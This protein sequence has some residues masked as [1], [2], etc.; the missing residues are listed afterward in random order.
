MK[1]LLILPFILLTF[2][3]F[4]QTN[5]NIPNVVAGSTQFIPK[6]H[7]LDT[8]F[9]KQ[10]FRTIETGTSWQNSFFWEIGLIHASDFNGD[11]E[12]TDFTMYC[13]KVAYTFTPF[14]KT[15]IEGP[16]VSAELNLFFLTMR[17]NMM[18]YT[19][20]YD[21]DTHHDLRF[22]PEIG[23]TVFGIT[24]VCYGWNIPLLKDRAQ[25]LA[26][27]RWSVN[28]NLVDWDF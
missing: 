14:L 15:S 28:V 16:Q 26:A 22:T 7:W 2:N 12:G 11:D 25:G 20:R 1:H 5:K 18:Y 10:P 27:H 23:L 19:S 8:I 6:P 13:Y 9:D 17:A 21:F 3:C 24:T 4:G